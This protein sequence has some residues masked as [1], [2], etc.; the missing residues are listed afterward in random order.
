MFTVH[1]IKIYALKV[2]VHC[3]LSVSMKTTK[4]HNNIEKLKFTVGKYPNKYKII[5]M[6]VIV[7]WWSRLCVYSY[8]AYKKKQ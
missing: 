4:K 2:A 7:D 5:A 1:T 6:Y 3:C 8:V